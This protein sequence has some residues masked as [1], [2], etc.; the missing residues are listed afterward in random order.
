MQVCEHVLAACFLQDLD[1]VDILFEGGEAPILDGSAGPYLRAIRHAGIA[2]EPRPH[3]LRLSITWQRHTVSWPGDTQ[4]ERART[5]IDLSDG[6]QLLSSG[7]F[8]GAR[9]DCALVFDSTG[10]SRYGAR[11]RFPKEPA[12]HKLLDLMGDLGPYRAQGRLEGDLHVKNPA[13]QSNGVSIQSALADGRL[14]WQR[15]AKASTLTHRS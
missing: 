4:P 14:R 2:G 7:L 8:R 9:P 12:W 5:F 15:D 13:H 3:G 10:S 11:P 1:D 6:A